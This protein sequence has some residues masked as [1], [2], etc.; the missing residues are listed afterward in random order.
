M[1][2]TVC[3]LAFFACGLFACQKN[4]PDT[5]SAQQSEIGTVTAKEHGSEKGRGLSKEIRGKARGDRDGRPGGTTASHGSGN[6]LGFYGRS[7]K[8]LGNQDGRPGGKSSEHGTGQGGGVHRGQGQASGN[9]DGMPGGTTAEH[10]SGDGKGRGGGKR[11]AARGNRD[12]KPGD[13]QATEGALLL[14]QSR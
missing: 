5:D 2:R 13:P 14:K 11:G 12:G 6:G 8:A 9:R 1:N 4:A 10:G 3:A 7:G